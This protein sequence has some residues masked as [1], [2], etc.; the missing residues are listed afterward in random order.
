[1]RPLALLLC[2]CLITPNA[3]GDEDVPL[4]KG[5]PAPFTGIILTPDS[6]AL[7][8]KEKSELEKLKTKTATLEELAKFK[9]GKYQELLDVKEKEI[10]AWRTQAEKNAERT[11]WDENK[12]Q[13]GVLLG[14]VTTITVTFAV[15]ETLK[16]TR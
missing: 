1:M 10:A 6:Y 11:W 4:A 9:E 13:V 7:T 12:L 8:V 2:I 5:S 3:W 16:V 14:I 15:A